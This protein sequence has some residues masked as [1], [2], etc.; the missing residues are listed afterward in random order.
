MNDCDL[1]GG[2]V[3]CDEQCEQC[4]FVRHTTCCEAAR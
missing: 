3:P 2:P 1:C 4:A